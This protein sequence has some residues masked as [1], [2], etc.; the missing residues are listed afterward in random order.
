MHHHEFS[1]VTASYSRAQ[2]QLTP[3]IVSGIENTPV[4]QVSGVV[5][6]VAPMIDRVS[7]VAVK[8]AGVEL[9]PASMPLN[10]LL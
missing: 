10:E 9:T 7:V 8:P 6:L 5:A 4:G 2:S 1:Q 3:F